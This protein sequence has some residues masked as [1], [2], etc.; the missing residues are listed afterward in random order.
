MVRAFDS[1]VGEKGGQRGDK[2]RDYVDAGGKVGLI[3]RRT[4][5]IGEELEFLTAR[6]L[7]SVDDGIRWETK[8]T[9][10]RTCNGWRR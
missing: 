4:R 10:T 8:N 3:G 9:R 2:G 7:T 5:A 6:M 1:G